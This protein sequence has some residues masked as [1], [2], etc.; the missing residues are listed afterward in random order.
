MQAQRSQSLSDLNLYLV[1][2]SHVALFAGFSLALPLV[3]PEV[4]MGLKLWST[5]LGTGIA[6]WGTVLVA[7]VVVKAVRTL[8]GTSATAP[9]VPQLEDAQAAMPA[10]AA[11]HPTIL[12]ADKH[13]ADAELVSTAA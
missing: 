11:T 9:A 8:V 12:L 10:P 2:G 3:L 7:G 6:T 13:R 4:P 5:F 1:V